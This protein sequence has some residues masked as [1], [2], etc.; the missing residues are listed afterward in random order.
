MEDE[1]ALKSDAVLGQFADSFQHEVNDLFADRVVTAS[2]VIGR[3]LLSVDHLLRMKQTAI[4]AHA[5][6]V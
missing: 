1:E 6:L 2:I 3:I 5:N 4:R